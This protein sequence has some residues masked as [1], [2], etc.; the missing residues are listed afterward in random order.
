MVI[1]VRILVNSRASTWDE[2]WTM[3]NQLGGSYFVCVHFLNSSA[4][5]LSYVYFT[6]CIYYALIKS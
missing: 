5:D 1:E 6:V 3:L 4:Q 2:A